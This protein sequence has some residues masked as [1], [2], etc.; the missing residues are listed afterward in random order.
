MSKHHADVMD[1][2]DNGS[3]RGPSL[4]KVKLSGVAMVKSYAEEWA[5]A[6]LGVLQEMGKKAARDY[7]AVIGCAIDEYMM[8]ELD[9]EGEGEPDDGHESNREEEKGYSSWK[10][11][12]K[13]ESLA[14]D[15]LVEAFTEKMAGGFGELLE[16]GH[17]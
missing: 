6:Y 7:E 2:E 3:S 16:I 13:S 1:G 9:H 8:E 5:K 14:H 12:K 17:F 15:D 11:V 4:K 10:C